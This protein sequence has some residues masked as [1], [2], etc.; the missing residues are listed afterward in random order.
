[1][2]NKYLKN[3]LL[4]AV[5]GAM[6]STVAMANDAFSVK[7]ESQLSL[8]VPN[9]MEQETVVYIWPEPQQ[10]QFSLNQQQ[11]L[12]S[13]EY[14]QTVTGSEL[15]KGVKVYASEKA[16]LRLAPMAS[17]ESG[18]RQVSE[19]LDMGM[20]SLNADDGKVT[21]SQLAAQR[22][23]EAAGFRDGSI[24]FNVANQSNQALTL[25]SSQ[26]LLADAKYLIHVKEKGSANKLQVSAPRAFDA[27]KPGGFMLNADIAGVKLN[28]LTTRV[29]LVAPNGEVTQAR[30]IAGKVN[31]EHAPSQVGA[32]N[33]FHELQIT[34]MANV[35]GQWVKRSTKV[36]FINVVST[37]Q[38]DMG[39]IQ[40]GKGKAA[41]GVEVS[42][43][44]R[45]NITATLQGVN[46]NGD[47]VRLQTLDTASWMQADTQVALPFEF[48][49]FSGYSQLELVDVKLMDQSRLM[50]LQ[51]VPLL[52]AK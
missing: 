32:F 40:L 8:P 27:G 33:G 50:D 2:N 12:Q 15:N 36:P 7:G 34:G 20:V 16:L 45:Y 31:F 21:V 25:R 9:M 38:L 13:D 39:S 47:K 52:A 22:D 29:Q 28:P 51:Y 42:E 14:W 41:I 17:T 3:L 24:A 30:L 37:A 1:M 11:Q 4:V 5:A 43:P 46:A 49:K 26:P 48:A 19:A 35:N 10:T 23:M 44:G 6:T 18:A